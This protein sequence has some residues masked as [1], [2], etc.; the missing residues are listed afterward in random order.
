VGSTIFI[1]GTGTGVG[2]TILTALLTVHLR[3][4]GVNALAMKPYCSG[5]LNDSELLEAANGGELSLKQ[6]TP[7]FC[8]KPLAPLAALEREE[9]HDAL[10]EAKRAI[11]ENSEQCEYLLVEGIGGVAV[12]LAPSYS[13][14]HLIAE[15]A[16]HQIIVGTNRLGII[17]ETILTNYFLEGLGKPRNHIVLMKKDTESLS[18]ESNTDIVKTILGHSRLTELPF[19]GLELSDIRAIEACQIKISKTLAQIC[20]W[21]KFSSADRRSGNTLQREAKTT[22]LRG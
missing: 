21:V 8:P 9:S 5:S 12:P 17:N 11:S 14:G 1:T 15:I 10:Q 6:I 7:V 19:L 3:A 13:V 20:G 18:A 2:K 4:S 22:N 16:D